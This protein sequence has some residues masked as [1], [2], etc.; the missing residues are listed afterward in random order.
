VEKEITKP[1]PVLTAAERHLKGASG[2]KAKFNSEAESFDGVVAPAASS[3][4]SAGKKAV[5]LS[6]YLPR[7]LRGSNVI[8]QRSDAKGKGRAD[9]GPE[10]EEDAQEED[11][12]QDDEE[13]EDDSD[14]FY[15]YEDS[16][17]DAEDNVH[18]DDLM[19]MREAA[20]EYHAKRYD[21]G[22]GAGTGPLGGDKEVDA[23]QD[24]SFSILVNIKE[25][26]RL[27]SRS[28][29]TN[30]TKAFRSQHHTTMT[31]ARGSL[32]ASAR[33]VFR[34]LSCSFPNFSP[35]RLTSNL[36]YY[37]AIVWAHTKHLKKL[38]N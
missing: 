29:T 14:G 32:H 38:A 15:N 17:E 18:I 27:H 2:S 1:P 33:G 6:A 9:E 34:R 8:Q 35:A 20:L 3:S 13:D 7:S 4:S 30:K 10:D 23:Y 36:R 21:L 19:A 22:A 12:D 37:Q 31:M 26:N 28:I 25:A 16:D 24:V 11:Y 5:D